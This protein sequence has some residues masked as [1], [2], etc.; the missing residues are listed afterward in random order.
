M[1]HVL[2]YE[3]RPTLEDTS[4]V[5]IGSFYG[6]PLWALLYTEFLFVPCERNVLKYYEIFAASVTPTFG[7]DDMGQRLSKSA[8]HACFPSR[9]ISV[10]ARSAGSERSGDLFFFRVNDTL[11]VDCEMVKVLY[12]Y[13]CAKWLR[14]FQWT[15]YEQVF[16]SYK[17]C[18]L[19]VFDVFTEKTRP[20]FGW[21]RKSFLKRCVSGNDDE[22]SIDE[23]IDEAPVISFQFADDDLLMEDERPVPCTPSTFALLSEC[24]TRIPF[25]LWKD[26]YR[27]TRALFQVDGIADEK[28]E[29]CVVEFSPKLAPTAREFRVSAV[30][31]W[32]PCSKTLKRLKHPLQVAL[33]ECRALNCR[34][35]QMKT[36][37]IR[38]KR[39]RMQEQDRDGSSTFAFGSTSS[40]GPNVDTFFDRTDQILEIKQYD[41]WGRSDFFTVC[42]LNRVSNGDGGAR[43]RLRPSV[44]I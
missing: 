24:Q 29:P 2:D 43:R 6:V 19:E 28:D 16:R 8:R 44:G 38:Y 1:K 10:K 22:V 31:L 34:S 12:S 42:I 13:H 3:K 35:L 9:T 5:W 7:E 4:P 39:K 15:G 41:V 26:R 40:V 30:R 25:G 23:S 17:E 18:V 21:M 36:P 32:K 27:V 11:V 14:S 33:A 37:K 20:A